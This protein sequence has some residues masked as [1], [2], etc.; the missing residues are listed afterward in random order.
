MRLTLLFFENLTHLRLIKTKNG[1]QTLLRKGKA[2]Y[3]L[4]S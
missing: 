3:S 2:S 1:L 4:Y